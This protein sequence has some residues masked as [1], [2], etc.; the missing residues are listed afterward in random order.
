M[1]DTTREPDKLVRELPGPVL[2]LGASGFIGSNLFRLL[3]KSSDVVYGTASVM[4]AWRLRGIPTENIFVGDLLHR[5][6]LER[7]LA[8]VQ[9]QTVF[10]CMAYGAYPFQNDTSLIY[11]T[12][13]DLTV[14]LV[15]LLLKRRSIRYVHAGSCSEYGANADRPSEEVAP[16]PNS[17]YA[18]S[19]SAAASLL[20]FAGRHRGLACANLRL[21]SVYGPYEDPSRLIPTLITEGLQGRLPNLVNPDISRDV[22]YVED[23][24]VAFLL[25]AL[26]LEPSDYG[27][28]FNICSGQKTTIREIASLSREVFQ[29]E[30]EP[31]FETMP[32]RMW[33][34]VNWEGNPEKA[35]QRLGFETQ[36]PL[37]QGLERTINWLHSLESP[38]QYFQSSK[39]TT[40]DTSHSVSVVVACYKDGQAIPIIHERL[41]AEFNRLGIDYEIIFVNDNSP[42]D[43]EEVIRRLSHQDNR[44]IGV[45]HSRNFGSQA[46]FRSGMELASKNSCVLMDGDLQDPPEIIGQFVEKWRQGNEVVYGR[47]V[48]REAP[49]HMQ[50]AYK[51]FYW[52]FDRFSYIDIPRDAGDFSLIDKRV[53][54]HLLGFPERD[55][56]LRGLRA[57]V[58]FK[59]VGVDYVRPERMF[60]RSTNSLVK[61]IQWAKKGIFSFSQAPLNFLTFLGALLFILSAFLVITTVA[62]KLWFPD[63]VPQGITTVTVLITLFG[64]LNLLAISLVGEYVAKIMDETKGRPLFIRRAF[65]K[66]GRIREA[67][68]MEGSRL[69]TRP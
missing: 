33:D 49:W 6:H 19:K 14:R 51:I 27:G 61:N 30:Q 50:I 28:S 65:I 25:A 4:P 9:P 44:V 31:V 8:K 35:R 68:D 66:G 45:S 37:R 2:V 54:Q 60:G 58:G 26:N 41:T 17:H 3:Q 21:Y 43:S 34:V 11:N 56:F 20:Y 22:I 12:N 18:V 42:D 39:Q 48:K 15:E 64:S 23:V 59:Q 57:F 40:L 24:C 36:V 53:V 46:A 5:D 69:P 52:L 16:T 29:I 1:Q 55:M 67:L 13:V 63:L 38:Q 47:R 7:L 62:L 10:N 32:D